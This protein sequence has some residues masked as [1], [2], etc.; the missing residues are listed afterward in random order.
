MFDDFL[1]SP[2]SKGEFSSKWGQQIILVGAL[3]VSISC[4]STPPPEPG[5][6]PSASDL[7]MLGSSRLCDEKA[8]VLSQWKGTIFSKETWGSGERLQRLAQS[9]QPNHDRFYFFDDDDI[10]VGAIFRYIPGLSLKPFPVLRQTLSKLTPSSA[11]FLDPTELLQATKAKSAILYRTGDK[12]STTQYVVLED[13]EHS[14]LLV[15]SMAIDPYEQLLSSYQ[16]SY[17]PGLVLMKK[18]RKEKD[19]ESGKDKKFLALQQVARGQAAM[20]S[21]CGKRKPDVA[22][23]AY[24]QAVEY[25]FTDKVRLAESHHRLGVALLETGQVKDAQVKLEKALEIRPNVPEVLNN[26]GTVLA[27]QKKRPQAVQLFEQAIVLRPNYARARFNLAEALEKVNVQ[28][29]IE[30]YETYLVLVEGISEE[31]QRVSLAEVRLKQLK[32]EK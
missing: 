29:A 10:L 4:S 23:D 22:V 7:E 11:F 31:E 18:A 13:E 32:G 25:G 2:N 19:F 24:S 1:I 26:L 14:V 20:L 15:A 8:L 6:P 28:R 17:L 21:S 9:H 16:E 30:E 5:L 27:Q 12:T 3:L